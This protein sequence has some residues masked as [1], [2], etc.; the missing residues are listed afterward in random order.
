MNVFGA[1]RS[2]GPDHMTYTGVTD[3]LQSTGI[4]RGAVGSVRRIMQAAE[5]RGA[6]VNGTGVQVIAAHVLTG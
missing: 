3:A 5:S 1:T 6:A 2:I 4:G